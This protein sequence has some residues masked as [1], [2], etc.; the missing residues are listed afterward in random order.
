MCQPVTHVGGK[1]VK[2]VFKIAPF[3]FVGIH[4]YASSCKIVRNLLE[5]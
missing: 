1:F 2:E 3:A 5:F 4:Y